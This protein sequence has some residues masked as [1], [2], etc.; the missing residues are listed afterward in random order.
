[1]SSTSQQVTITIHKDIIEEVTTI[2]DKRGGT[3]N[4]VYERLLAAGLQQY[5]KGNVAI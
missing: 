1:M 5:Y 2:K 4:N 3:K